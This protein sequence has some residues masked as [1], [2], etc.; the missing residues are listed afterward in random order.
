MQRADEII[1]LV[2]DPVAEAL[3][4]LKPGKEFTLQGFYGEGASCRELQRDD[5]VHPVAFAPEF[6]CVALTDTPACSP[7]RR[8]NRSA[9]R[10]EDAAWM[11]P[12][13]Q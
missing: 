13:F 3:I 11:L 5:R 9:G 10:A 8:T 12:V 1:H 4:G 2:A 6:S 7:I